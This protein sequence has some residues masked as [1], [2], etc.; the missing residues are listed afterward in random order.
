MKRIFSFVLIA[1]ALSA[2]SAT[3]LREKGWDDRVIGKGERLLLE[4]LNQY[5]EG[6]FKKSAESLNGALSEGLAFTK[7]RVTAHKY[8]AF[9]DCAAGREAACREQ[10]AAALAL[11]PALELTSAEAGHP[12]WGPVF[13]TVKTRIARSTK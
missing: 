9:I 10:F 3:S 12:A 11:D 6:A 8:L 2:C 13:K 4:G 5:E 1:L 7:D